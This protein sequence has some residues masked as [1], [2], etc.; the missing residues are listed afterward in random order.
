MGAQASAQR[1]LRRSRR[2]FIG[3]GLHQSEGVASAYLAELKLWTGDLVRAGLYADRAWEL[4]SVQKAQGDSIRAALLQG[5][6]ALSVGDLS[7][8]DERL[9]HALTRT[10]AV[11]A[12]EFELPAV[13][14]IAELELERGDPAKAKASLDDVWEAAERGPYP[15]ERADALN[16]LTG[17][18]LAEGDDAAAIAAAINAFKA[19]WCGGPPYAYHWGLEKAKAHLAALGAPEVVLPRFDESKFGPLPKVA[20][21]PKT[22]NKAEPVN[23]RHRAV[24][25][26]RRGGPRAG[27]APIARQGRRLPRGRGLVG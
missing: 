5:R 17:I 23:L 6:V 13:I 16:V 11:N 15:L 22:K 24:T 10:R 26:A 8:S 19:A 14:A 25:E 4:A 2:L 21:N 20:I 9:H 18:A 12:V 7:R 3:Q 1:A 27:S